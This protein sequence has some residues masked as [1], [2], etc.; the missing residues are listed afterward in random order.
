LG[1]FANKVALEFG[2]CPQAMEDELPPEE[3]MSI[4]SLTLRKQSGQL[5]RVVNGWRG[6]G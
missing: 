5:L 6:L 3:V 2:Q 1:S 4:F